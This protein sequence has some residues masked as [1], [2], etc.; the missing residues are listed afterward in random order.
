MKKKNRS[1]S[2]DQ[3][4]RKLRKLGVAKFESKA[5]VR[6]RQ[7]DLLRR[8]KAAGA[9]QDAYARLARCRPGRCAR[10]QCI[11]ACPFG[12]RGFRAREVLAAYRLFKRMGKP[13]YEVHHT[14][15]AWEKR[16]GE[17]H[18]VSIA[19]VKKIHQRAL[20]GL[21]NSEIVAVGLIKVAVQPEE[22]SWAR[23]VEL[24]KVPFEPL[25]EFIKRKGGINA[26]AALYAQ[27]R[28]QRKMKLKRWWED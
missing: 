18:R 23:Y 21:Y 9:D 5:Q 25:A 11:D 13:I 15:D 26:C 20:D 17:L 8:L 7:T 6:K 24:R 27:H 19:G 28:R 1:R 12:A 10:K 2:L 4:L 16:K 3:Q 14:R 22:P